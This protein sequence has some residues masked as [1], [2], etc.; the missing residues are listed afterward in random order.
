MSRYVDGFVIPLEKKKL[1]AY[2]KMATLGRKVW[3]EY[4]ALDFYECVGANLET[5]H[6]VSFSKLYKLKKGETLLFSF[7]VYKS[8]SHRDRVVAKV[9]KDPRMN[10]AGP[11]M[12]FD[13][14]RFSVGEFKTILHT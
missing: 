8:K 14:K 13:M 1:A 9:M 4:G 11:E 2:K 7:I 3:M 12:P 10:E 6:G 5:T